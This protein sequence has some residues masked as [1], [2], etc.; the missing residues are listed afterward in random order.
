MN[1]SPY[2]ESE[3]VPSEADVVADTFIYYQLS[4]YRRLIKNLN[5]VAG[6]GL[7]SLLIV[8]S[9]GW[10][11]RFVSFFSWYFVWRGSLKWLM[12]KMQ[13]DGFEVSNTFTYKVCWLE[14]P[15]FRVATCSSRRL[16][17]KLGDV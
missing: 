12:V 13:E 8:E 15:A 2:R 7:P 17:A 4:L 9:Q 14:L 6:A 16:I 3:Y 5:F 1:E 11:E 10:L